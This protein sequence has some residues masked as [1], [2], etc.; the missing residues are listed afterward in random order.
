MSVCYCRIIIT[1]Y[2]EISFVLCSV[3]YFGIR[4]NW[5]GLT[6]VKNNFGLKRYNWTGLTVVKNNF[7]LKRYNWTGLTVV[8]N[9]FG[10]RYNWT[11]LTIVKI[12][13]G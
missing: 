10:I 11:G 9:N 13:L 3:G 4:Y 1:S 7:G 6:V 8:K 5:T 2:F 12:I